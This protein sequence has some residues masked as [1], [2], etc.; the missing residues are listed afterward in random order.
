MRSASE[1]DV[2][3]CNTD[4]FVNGDSGFDSLR[5]LE[6]NQEFR[7]VFEEFEF[8]L[9]NADTAE[10]NF[11]VKKVESSK[12]STRERGVFEKIHSKK[13]GLPKFQCECQS[14]KE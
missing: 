12:M 3:K 7:E 5:D 4:H 8:K 11:E 2:K 13:G 14:I 10:K 1:I 6:D 9:S